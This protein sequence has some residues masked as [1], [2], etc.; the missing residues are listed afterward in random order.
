MEEKKISDLHDPDPSDDNIEGEEEEEN[1]NMHDDLFESD[2]SDTP[3]S[4]RSGIVNIYAAYKNF[5]FDN[6]Q[7][8]LSIYQ[9]K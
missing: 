6:L 3:H 8:L 9:E 4:Q 5:S 1:K 7:Q 2:N